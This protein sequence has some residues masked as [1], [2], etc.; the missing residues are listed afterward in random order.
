MNKFEGIIICTDLDGT[1][2]KND[3]SI[4]KE[5]KKAIEYFQS[6]GGLFTFVYSLTMS[7]LSAYHGSK[8]EAS[9]K[10]RTMDSSSSDSFWVM[11]N[12]ICSRSPFVPD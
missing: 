11:A 9:Y 4:S 1:L 2:L 12:H 7:H 3:K 6:E 8:P 10:R 5:N